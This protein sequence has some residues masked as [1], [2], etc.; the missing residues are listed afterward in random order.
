VPERQLLAVLF[1]CALRRVFGPVLD[2]L[3]ALDQA[4]REAQDD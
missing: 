1:E 4:E 3:I 2:M